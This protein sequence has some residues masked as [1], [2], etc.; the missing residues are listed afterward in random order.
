M[1]DLPDDIQD[2]ARELRERVG[3]EFRAEA[4][5]GERLA[6]LA[7][8]RSRSL[9]DVAVEL[10]SR[11]DRVMISVVGRSFTGTI[12]YSGQNF[13]TL[14]GPRGLTDVRLTA[15]VQLQVLERAPAGGL[16]PLAGPGTFRGRLRELELDGVEVEVGGSGLPEPLRG[17]IVTVGRDHV[18]VR[19]GDGADRYLAEAGIAYVRRESTA[20]DWERA[21]QL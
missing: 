10:R 11:G 17:R 12:V 5:E 9:A 15:A 4:E 19:G 6:A 21:G 14:R 13:C 8:A 7:A 3:G 16:G 2:L 20:R 1:S 18:R